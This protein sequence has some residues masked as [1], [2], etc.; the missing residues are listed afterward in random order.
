MCPISFGP[1][2]ISSGTVSSGQVRSAQ[3]R[4][5][6]RTR[7]SSRVAP[8]RRPPHHHA[9]GCPPTHIRAGRKLPRFPIDIALTWVNVSQGLSC[10]VLTHPGAG[11]FT[12]RRESALPCVEDRTPVPA[13]TTPCSGK[14]D[15]LEAEFGQSRAGARAAAVAAAPAGRA[16]RRRRAGLRPAARP[17]R[18][19]GH[20]VVEHERGVHG[21]CGG[22]R[23]VHH[24]RRAGP[25]RVHI[26]P[27][28]VA[29]LDPEHPR[30]HRGPAD[31]QPV[32]HA[33]LRAAVRARHLRIE[34]R[35]AGLPGRLLH[36]GGRPRPQPR[37]TPRSSARSTPS[38]S[39]PTATRPSASRWRT[40]GAPSR[41]SP[42]TPPA[43]P[44]AP[45]TPSSGRCLRPRRCAGSR[46]TATSR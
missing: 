6:R 16:G 5:R 43:G 27:V 28:D 38:T 37:R 29:G 46:S 4:S 10:L 9:A 39:A 35:P 19:G 18:L 41:I 32:R 1:I 20:R 25:E 11:V 30:R 12:G 23:A 36:R 2:R 44:A 13:W 22:R 14:A 17:G 8:V 3:G 42:S 34:R 40:S 45:R 7:S 26:H 31:P 15:R 33:A 21:G 24:R